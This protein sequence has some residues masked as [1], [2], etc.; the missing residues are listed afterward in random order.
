L[1]RIHQQHRELLNAIERQD[2]P[3]TIRIISDHI[4]GSQRERL[5][6]FDQNRREAAIRKSIPDF[7]ELYQP[8]KSR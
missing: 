5:E 7:L 2:G 3:E 8:L 6:E 1:D 4:Q